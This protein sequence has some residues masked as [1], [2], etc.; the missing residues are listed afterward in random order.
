MTKM[1]QLQANTIKAIQ[2]AKDMAISQ[3]IQGVNST[4]IEESKESSL[5]MKSDAEVIKEFLAYSLSDWKDFISNRD[6]TP[7][8]L[9]GII[10]TALKVVITKDEYRNNDVLSYVMYYYHYLIDP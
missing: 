7:E 8:K 9:I 3:N 1:V 5:N 4:E 10:N 6:I 2:V